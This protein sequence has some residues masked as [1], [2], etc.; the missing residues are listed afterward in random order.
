MII[1]L[2]LL[3]F[4]LYLF[5]YFVNEMRTPQQM[6]YVFMYVFISFFYKN[7]REP[8]ICECVTLLIII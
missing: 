2:L 4:I 5:I 1:T 6:Y 3:L 7:N 8:R